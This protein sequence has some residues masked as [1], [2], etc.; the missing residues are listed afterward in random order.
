MRR[1]ISR[2]NCVEKKKKRKGHDKKGRKKE[3][4]RKKKTR[5]GSNKEESVDSTM[6]KFKNQNQNKK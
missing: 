4:E 3:R 2:G 5:K 1:N 6:K